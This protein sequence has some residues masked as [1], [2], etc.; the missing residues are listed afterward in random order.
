MDREEIVRL[1]KAYVWHPYTPMD[2]WAVTDPIVV[3]RAD[4]A[5]LEDI[6]GRRYLDGNASWWVAA[7]GHGH[8][9]ILRALEKQAQTL[10]HCALAGIAHEP[11]ARLA[12][13]L[14]A[15]APPGLARVFFVD[16]GSTAIDAAI[17]MCVQG[18]RQC[19][20][21]NKTRFLALDGAYHGDT[22]G[23]T[24][25]GGVDVFRRPF[26]GVTFDCVHAPFPEPQAYER[27]LKTIARLL[28]EDADTIAAVFVEP[29]LQ[30]AAGMRIYDAA[31]LQELRAL[32]DRHDVWL[33]ADEVFTGFGRTGPMWACEHAGITPDLM[34]IGKAL[35]AIVP[36]GAVMT[37]K[38]VTDAFRGSRERAFMHGHTFCGNP[39]G[40][41]LAREVLAIYRDERVLDQV[42]QKEPIVARGFEKLSNAPSVQ[43]VRSIGL[44][45]AADLADEAPGYLG[46]VGW[47]VYEEARRRGA[48]LRPLGSTVYVCPPLTISESELDQLLGI[49]D[50]SVRAARD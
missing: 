49:L 32:C 7:L 10:D 19:G 21:R 29:V 3:S 22:I 46:G 37:T 9:R 44:V 25:L 6:D 41:A 23:A 31:L 45:G 34:C 40:S 27:A 43:R 28:A 30:G 1:D 50:E 14:V 12:Q 48:Y 47:R 16:D 36:M 24:S 42:A 33:V 15:I 18:W 11:A 38:H 39:I 26:A 8:P 35:S 4:G 5:W 2:A 13:E 17:K 20:A